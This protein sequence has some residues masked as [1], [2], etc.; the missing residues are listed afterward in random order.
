MSNGEIL[1]YISKNSF[2][3]AQDRYQPAPSDALIINFNVN[4][5]ATSAS[6]VRINTEV[7]VRG[8]ICVAQG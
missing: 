3:H 8:T 7:R 6:N 1:G 5:G 4:Q 2:G